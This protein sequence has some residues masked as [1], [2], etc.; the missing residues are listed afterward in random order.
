[1]ILSV[2]YSQIV[3][4]NWKFE[5]LFQNKITQFFMHTFNIDKWQSAEVDL[6]G[7]SDGVWFKLTAYGLNHDCLR[8]R[9]PGIESNLVAA[10]N[11]LL[12]IK[13]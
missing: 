12:P 11:A 10:W 13:K 1:M 9:L 7:E 6:T 2:I 5:V 4:N 3:E 8:A